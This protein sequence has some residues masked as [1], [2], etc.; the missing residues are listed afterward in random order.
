MTGTRSGRLV[1]LDVARCLALLGMVAT[2]VLDERTPAG[3][4]TTAQW[5]AGGR[6]SA[7][8]A[9][10]A[11][12][13][14]RAD[15]PRAAAGSAARAAHPRHRRPGAADRRARP[16]ARWPGHRH[17]DH[18]HLLRRAV[19]PGPAVHAPGRPRAPAAHRRVG[20]PRAGGLAPGAAAP[21]GAGVRQPD[22]PA[23][24]R[25]RAAGE[26]AA[27][28]RLLPG[29][30]VA[31]LPPRRSRAR[32]PRPARHLAAR[33]PGPRRTLGGGAR[34]A[35]LAVAGRPGGR[36]GERH[37]DVR[38]DARRRRL[39]LAAA[40]RAPLGDAVRP[41]PD[42]RQR[43]PG[44]RALPARRAAAAPTGDRGSRRPLRS[45]RGDAHALLAARRDAH[46]GR[47]AAGGA[48]DLP[49][50]RRGAPGDRGG[51]PAAPG[52]RPARGGGEPAGPAGP[53]GRAGAEPQRSG[54]NR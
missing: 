14:P 47:V 11:G 28:H 50:P 10:L 21:A 37:R 51:A 31:G 13:E 9:V 27:P 15:D 35:G 17:R 24:R 33:R 22:L 8:F 44:D 4:L 30:A 1:G 52:P 48:L 5:L 38:H 49:H 53:D 29:R 54:T 6:A 18:P 43:G 16:A 40:R 3:D 39:G 2:H 7:L 45:G 36:V 26:R 12:R 46:R 34:D 41:R 25:P 20:R 32:S 19:R 42:H 23:A